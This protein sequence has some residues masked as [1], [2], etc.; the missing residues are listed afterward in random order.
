MSSLQQRVEEQL[1]LIASLQSQ[2]KLLKGGE[3]TDVTTA[4]GVADNV[5]QLQRKVHVRV[6]SPSVLVGELQLRL[7]LVARVVPSVMW[8][9]RRLKNWLAWSRTATSC[10]RR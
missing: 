7:G 8:R 5:A 9:P 10:L 1:T 2:L 4:K 3:F 6:S